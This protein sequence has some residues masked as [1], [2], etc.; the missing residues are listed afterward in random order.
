MAER[1][2][3]RRMR[4]RTDQRP[5]VT[6]LRQSRQVFANVDAGRRRGDRLKLAADFRRGVGL[7]IK[8]VV[9]RQAPERNTKMTDLARPRRETTSA[10]CNAAT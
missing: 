3:I 9:L 2:V 7:Q 5:Q 8:A 1:M 10:A 6:A 4:E